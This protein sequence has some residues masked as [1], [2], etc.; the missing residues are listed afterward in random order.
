[1]RAAEQLRPLPTMS[2]SVVITE[3]RTA[4][5]QALIHWRGNRYSVP[6]EL[7]MATVSVHQPLGVDHIE[8]TTSSGV[9]I[10]RHQLA[11]PGLGFTQRT[12]QHVTA[13]ESIA[14]APAPPGRLTAAR[15]V[16]HRARPPWPLPEH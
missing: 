14:L 8:I 2:F 10:A 15:N 3:Q 11:E 5:R 6:P 1:M 13:L 12:N 9:A 4:S 7:A 16:S